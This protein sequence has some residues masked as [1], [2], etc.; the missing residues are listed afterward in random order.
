MYSLLT[1]PVPCLHPS[2]HWSCDQSWDSGQVKRVITKK[3]KLTGKCPFRTLPFSHCEFV[4][5]LAHSSSKPTRNKKLVNQREREEKKERKFCGEPLCSHR[6]KFCVSG[7]IPLSLV[8]ELALTAPGLLSSFCASVLCYGVCRR[9]GQQIGRGGVQ[10]L[11]CAVRA[12]G[13][14]VPPLSGPTACLQPS[15]Q[16][17]FLFVD[18]L[19]SGFGLCLSLSPPPTTKHT[20]KADAQGMKRGWVERERVRSTERILRGK[21]ERGRDCCPPARPPKPQEILSRSQFPVEAA[22]TL[23]FFFRGGEYSL[24]LLVVQSRS[25]AV[26]PAVSAP[27][28]LGVDSALRLVHCR[29]KQTRQQRQIVYICFRAALYFLSKVIFETFPM[30]RKKEARVGQ[31]GGWRRSPILRNLRLRLPVTKGWWKER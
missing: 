27:P 5:T 12:D 28:A 26:L 24:T 21:R 4:C 20:K 1:C 3:K 16:G 2:I 7:L 23:V 19:R 31:T 8:S 9:T 25:T 18:P 15:Y 17:V 11:T 29:E 22:G 13:E 10:F 30:R 6:T 14:A